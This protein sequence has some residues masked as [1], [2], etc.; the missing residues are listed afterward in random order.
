MTEMEK[1]QQHLDEVCAYIN[2]LLARMGADLRDLKEYIREER[3]RI[4]DDYAHDAPQPEDGQGV[5][6]IVETEVRDVMRYERMNQLNE[7]LILLAD[8]PYFAR[9]DVR[10]AFGTDC[11][12]IGKRSLMDKDGFDMLVCDWRSDIASL[13]YDADLGPAKYQTDHEEINCE[14]LLRRQFR[15]ENGKILYLFDSDI[16]IEDDILKDELGKSSDT[17]LK[18]II[19]TLQREQSAIIR[20]LSADLV[21]VEGVAGSGKTSVALHRLAYLLYK[22]RKTL[23]SGNILLF[24]VNNVF[25]SYIAEVL[26]DLGEDRVVQSGFFD[27][28]KP[29]FAGWTVENGSGQAERIFSGDEERNNVLRKG[30]EAFRQRLKETFE[31]LADAE[32]QPHDI[33]FCNTI[34]RSAEEIQYLYGKEYTSYPPA[35]RRRKIC[36]GIL[37]QLEED[38]TFL[39]CRRKD[40]IREI[41][42]NGSIK[43]DD[44]ELEEEIRDRWKKEI[45]LVNEEVDKMLSVDV[46]KIYRAAIEQELPDL[47][48]KTEEKILAKE[49]SYEDFVALVYLKALCGEIPAQMHIHHLLIDE[50]QDNSPVIY[51]IFGL[52]FPEAKYTVVGD[53]QQSFVPYFSSLSAISHYF[54]HKKNERF[55]TLSKSYRSTAEINEYLQQ[56]FGISVPYFDRHGEAVQEIRASEKISYLDKIAQQKGKSIAVI[57][58]TEAESRALSERLKQNG[59]SIP[60]LSDRDVLFPDRTMI[61]PSNLTKGLEFDEVF[62]ADA[63]PENWPTENDRR[64]L[65]VCESRALHRLTIC[66]EHE[67]C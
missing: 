20:N 10:D 60:V 61:V 6:Q 53:S 54:T 18:T 67:E 2:G 4:W 36:N 62:L 46:V 26:P 49:L 64:A 42:E 30:C 45:Q 1:E 15:I 34:L 13:F 17:K 29:Y 51:A 9:L 28:F 32:I 57:C 21:L 16:A 40:Y 66:R 41:T 48:V 25:S 44:I 3:A 33:V 38:P 7:S 43:P 11:V 39:E 35:I 8:H 27:Y 58:K 55:F 63:S 5:Q 59:I 65:Y 47:A 19:S 37:A 22:F 23:S 24:T 31:A 56:Q 14:L 52:L 50:A 12:Y